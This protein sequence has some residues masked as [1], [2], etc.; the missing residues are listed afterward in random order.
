MKMGR[1]RKEKKMIREVSGVFVCVVFVA[2]N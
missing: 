2:I 1:R